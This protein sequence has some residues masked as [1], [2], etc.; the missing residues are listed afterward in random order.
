MDLAYIPPEGSNYAQNDMFDNIQNDLL[1]SNEREL[2]S[3]LMGDFN[4]RTGLLL[5]HENLDD[6]IVY[7]AGVDDEATKQSCNVNNPTDQK[8]LMPNGE[9]L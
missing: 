5:D 9:I 6:D 3:C 1:H 7:G 2:P 4:S 8:V